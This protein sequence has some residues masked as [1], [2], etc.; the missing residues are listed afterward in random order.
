MVCEVLRR[1]VAALRV[2]GGVGAIGGDDGG[3]RSLTKMKVDRHRNLPVQY[4]TTCRYRRR[5]LLL[6]HCAAVDE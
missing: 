6:R 1:D 4:R 2:A 3:D 5:R